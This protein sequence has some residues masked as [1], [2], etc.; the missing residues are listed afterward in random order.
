LRINIFPNEIN[1]YPKWKISILRGKNVSN[2]GNIYLQ[3]KIFIF[4]GKYL[5]SLDNISSISLEFFFIQE[6]QDLSLEEV[7]TE[8]EK[9]AIDRI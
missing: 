6:K 7:K 4:C 1:I 5:C 8:N 3:K 9:N 2:M